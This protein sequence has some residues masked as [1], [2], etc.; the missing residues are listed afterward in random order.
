MKIGIVIPT[1]NEKNNIKKLYD[2]FKKHPNL[3]T[4]ICFVDGSPNQDT[5]HEINKFFKKNYIIIPEKKKIV[6]TGF[7]TLSTRC[8]ASLMGFK[9]FL[10]NT[11]IELITDMDADLASNPSDI[12]KA[13]EIY[14][15]N[16]SDIIIA[17]K[18][19]P[20]SKVLKRNFIR[21]FISYI[22]TAG[23]RL[24]VSRKIS[25][26]SAGFRFF[27]RKSLNK[28]VKQKIRF[29]SPSQHLEILLF[30]YEN[31]YKISEFPAY[32]KDTQKKSTIQ[33]SH[34]FIF[35]FQIFIS[36]S[37]FKFRQLV[38]IFTKFKF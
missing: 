33:F 23:C 10:K 9:W 7:F 11:K 4:F 20:K 24:V 2:T 1:Y 28:M 17:S 15:K 25:D 34:L 3:D 5:T 36:L 8:H 19:L 35:G 29:L 31:K 13:I 27:S 16:K 14:K 32:Y 12:T 37:L 18:Y 22:Y 26:Y 38:N 30:Y 21:I 6:V